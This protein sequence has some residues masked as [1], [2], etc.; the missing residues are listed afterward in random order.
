MQ[1]SIN[2]IHVSFHGE[3]KKKNITFIF[4]DSDAQQ[5]PFEGK[6]VEQNV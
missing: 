3:N 2:N 4:S 6:L 5:I 1:V